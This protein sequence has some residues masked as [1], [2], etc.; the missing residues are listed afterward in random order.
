MNSFSPTPT[1]AIAGWIGARKSAWQPMTEE[2][3]DVFEAASRYDR[4]PCGLR[5]RDVPVA[6]PQLDAA[7]PVRQFNFNSRRKSPWQPQ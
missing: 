6:F 4:E 1:P 5:A 7:Y 2:R 3:H